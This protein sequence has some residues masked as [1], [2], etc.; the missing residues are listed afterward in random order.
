MLK[1]NPTYSKTLFKQVNNAI[2]TNEC[3]GD[4]Y[5]QIHT[6]LVSIVLKRQVITFTYFVP[7][8]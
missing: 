2:G 1:L 6:L 4:D 8:R 5:A 7:V 3:T